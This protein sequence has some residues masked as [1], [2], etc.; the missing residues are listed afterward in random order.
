ML[1]KTRQ[2]SH[3]LPRFCVYIYSFPF[4]LMFAARTGII[5]F[6]HRLQLETVCCF[7]FLGIIVRSSVWLGLPNIIDHI[8]VAN[9]TDVW[10]EVFCVGSAVRMTPFDKASL[11]LT[12]C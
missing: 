11:C 6:A 12:N 8:S 7:P 2:I 9:N 10:P 5:P 3:P 4:T 1:I